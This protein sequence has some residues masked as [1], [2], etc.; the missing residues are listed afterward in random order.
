MTPGLTKWNPEI[1]S[2]DVIAV[3]L[4]DGTPVAVGVAAFDIGRL[5]KAAGEKGKAV[6]LVHCYCDEL[7]A[8]G[9]KSSP[10]KPDPDS[11]NTELEDATLQL[12]LEPKEDHQQENNEQVSVDVVETIPDPDVDENQEPER[13]PSITGR[14]PWLQADGDIDNAFKAAAIYGLYQIK[15]S[16]AQNSL[17]LPMPSSTLVSNH[18]NPFLVEPFAQMTF[19]KTT[20]KKAATFLKKFLEKEGLVKTKDRGGETVILSINWDHKLITGFEPYNLDHRVLPKSAKDDSVSSRSMIQVEQLYKP[21]GKAFKAI[22]EAISKSYYS[23]D[24]LNNGV[25]KMIY[26]LDLKSASA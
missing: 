4:E 24:I 21:S 6:Y 22:L 18:L 10:P 25:E 14:R 1:Q 12:S 3:T 15:A 11:R 23:D 20:W 8:M 13:E 26:I 7:W 5:S 2:G 16:D 19:K 9:S 17:S